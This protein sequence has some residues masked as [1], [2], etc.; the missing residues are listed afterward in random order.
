MANLYLGRIKNIENIIMFKKKY[1]PKHLFSNLLIFE[2]ITRPGRDNRDS[3]KIGK[4]WKK[5]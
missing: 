1:I 5:L 2:K 3:A 4:M